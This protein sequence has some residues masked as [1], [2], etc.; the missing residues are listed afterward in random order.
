MVG[1]SQIIIYRMSNEYLWYFPPVDRGREICFKIP[2]GSVRVILLQSSCGDV[3]TILI[4]DSR[5]NYLEGI[6]LM[7]VYVLIS[8]AVYRQGHPQLILGSLRRINQSKN[9]KMFNFISRLS[10]PFLWIHVQLTSFTILSLHWNQ[11][12]HSSCY[13]PKLSSF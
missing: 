7:S 9:M 11:A 2:T 8:I 13:R 1:P 12:P 5:S 3:V 4:Q 6:L 10:V